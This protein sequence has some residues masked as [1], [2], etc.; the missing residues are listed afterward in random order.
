MV[1]LGV[2]AVVV[3]VVLLLLMLMLPLMVKAITTMS[4]ARVWCK[5][6]RASPAHSSAQSYSMCRNARCAIRSTPGGPAA[7]QSSWADCSRHTARVACGK[8]PGGGDD[9][10]PLV[11]PGRIRRSPGM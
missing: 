2:V 10:D 4:Q 11:R 3:V 6:L 5:S 8:R 9:D 1:I 7:C